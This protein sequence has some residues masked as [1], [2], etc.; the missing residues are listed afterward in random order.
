MRKL[1]IGCSLAQA[2]EEFIESIAILRKSLS[3]H[4]ITLEFIGLKDST[5]AKVFK[6]DIDCV[7]KCD[8]FLAECTYP[9]TGLGFEIATAHALNKKIIAVALKGSKVSR[10]IQGI[11]GKNFSFHW[12][13]THKEVLELVIKDALE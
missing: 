12:Y 4:F 2:P 13:K 1:Y 7:K 9:S 10:L 5:V 6:H 3:E 8:V 11:S